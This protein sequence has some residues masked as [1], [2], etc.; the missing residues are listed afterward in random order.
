MHSERRIAGRSTKVVISTV[1]S[2]QVAKKWYDG[3]DMKL[4]DKLSDKEK[5]R[6]EVIYE[7]IQTERDFVRDLD[8]IITVICFPSYYLFFKVFFFSCF[9]FY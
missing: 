5:K 7:L 8:I 6:Q 4:I 3:I 9:F 1:G 2:P